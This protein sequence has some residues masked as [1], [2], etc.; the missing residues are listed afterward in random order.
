MRRTPP[1]T[2]DDRRSV[3]TAYTDLGY[4][5]GVDPSGPP[6]DAVVVVGGPATGAGTPVLLRAVV[7][8]DRAGPLVVVG[9]EPV[10]T[11]LVGAVRADPSSAASA[12][13][14]DNIGTPHGKLVVAWA[15]ADQLAGTVGH[16]GTGTG[17]TLLPRSPS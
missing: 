11:D 5:A 9:G 2:A 7:E 15:V 10:G 6:A 1:V 14:V 12:S 16:Y 13:T 3:L 17:L 8:L 4:L